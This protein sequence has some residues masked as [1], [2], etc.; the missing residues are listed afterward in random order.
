MPSPSGLFQMQRNS[1]DLKSS[2]SSSSKQFDP[3]TLGDVHSPCGFD[4]DEKE[5]DGYEKLSDEVR[6]GAQLAGRS[7]CPHPAERV[8]G[9]KPGQHLHSAL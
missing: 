9:A 2:R 5:G 4:E 3:S 8:F 6:N 7:A 1:S